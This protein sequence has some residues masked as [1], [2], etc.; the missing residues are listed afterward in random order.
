LFSGFVVSL[1]A[2]MF[3]M[4]NW[5]TMMSVIFNAPAVIASTVSCV[6]TTFIS[7]LDNEC[8]SRHLMLSGI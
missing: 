4:L 2:T 6:A 5:N 3:M 1:I 8:R 7:L